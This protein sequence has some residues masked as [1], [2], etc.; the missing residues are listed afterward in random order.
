MKGCVLL[1]QVY[2]FSIC[3]QYRE[4]GRIFE[5][6]NMH[7]IMEQLRQLHQ[8]M[9]QIT[10]DLQNVQEKIHMLMSQFQ[11]QPSPF[12]QVHSSYAV[13]P[14]AYGR[15][16]IDPLQPQM[17]HPAATGSQPNGGFFSTFGNHSSVG[18][19][20]AYG[21]NT[22]YGTTGIN[23]GTALPVPGRQSETTAYGRM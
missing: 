5:E 18:G 8:E 23:Q 13:R 2:D 3:I 7:P 17:P 12:Q 10:Q 11:Q 9:L 20:S 22:S 1:R 6:G 4:I 14:S 19:N 21:H 16:D 15:S